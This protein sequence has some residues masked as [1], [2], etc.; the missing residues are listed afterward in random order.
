MPTLLQY[1]E[2]IRTGNYVKIATGW[3]FPPVLKLVTCT[4]NAA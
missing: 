1:Q 4:A 2:H 3:N